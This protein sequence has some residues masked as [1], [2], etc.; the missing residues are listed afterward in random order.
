MI[1]RVT[2]LAL[3]AASL[4]SAVTTAAGGGS[5]FELI[6]TSEYSAEQSVRAT[7]GPESAFV[8]K[9]S[10]PNAPS[11][12]VQS[13]DRA[14]PIHPPVDIDVRFKAAEGS[15]IDLSTL[16]ILYG[17]L[18]LDVT[19]RLLDAPGVQVSPAGLKA[20]GARLPSGSHKL[21]IQLADNFKRTGSQLL[22]FT[23]Q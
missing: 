10:D 17:L 11:I 15:T 14:A 7:A 3:I 19:R 23:I 4:L 5:G 13:P 21:I 8:M 22:E 2:S 18:K 12:T 1:T 9:S 6:S 16:K 20:S